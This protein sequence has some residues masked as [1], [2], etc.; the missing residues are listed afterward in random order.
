MARPDLPP[1]LMPSVL[2]RLIDPES[3]GTARRR[4]YSAE[5][6]VDAVRRDLEDLLN[7]RRTF[8][9]PAGDYPEVANSVV[10][11][12]L[13][14]L[15]SLNAYTPQQREAIG[16]VIEGAITQFEPRLR[17]VRATLKDPGADTQRTVRF[18]VDARL[19]M[20]PAPEVAFETILELTTGHASIR[21]SEPAS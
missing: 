17:D 2:D 14:D 8:S 21:P 1:A 3:G 12:G 16:R 13:P 6:V 19:A 15:A 18:H 9:V 20:E 7:T 11:Y 4:G 10:A 5:Q